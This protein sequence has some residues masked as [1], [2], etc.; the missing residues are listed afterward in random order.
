MKEEKETQPVRVWEATVK[1]S[2]GVYDFLYFAANDEE[3]ARRK[4]MED[5]EEVYAITEII[6]EAIV[7][8]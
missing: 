8:N 4:A 3:H 1:N 2:K 6:P 5:G 7:L